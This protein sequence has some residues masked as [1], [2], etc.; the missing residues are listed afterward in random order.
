MKPRNVAK[1]LYMH[2]LGY[3][4]QFGALEVIAL[5]AAPQFTAKRI[6]YLGLML[7]LDEE[8]ELLMMVTNSLRQDLTHLNQFVVGLALSA[9][10]N[11]GSA[12]MGRDLAPDIEALL[13]SPNAYIRKK[14]ALCA[15]R[16]VRK[17]PEMAERYSSKVKALLSDKNHG[18]VLT[19]L[20]L[21]IELCKCDPQYVAL[22]RPAVPSL[23][24]LLKSLVISGNSP[25][26]EVGGICDPFLQVK[27]L[28]AL[29]TLGTRDAKASDAMNDILAQVTTNTES[30]RNVGNAILYEAV[31]TILTIEASE[32]LRNLAI[33][34]LGRFLANRDNN[35][36]YVAL[37]SLSKVVNTN[38]SAVQ[39]HRAT[40][41]ENLKVRLH[42]LGVTDTSHSFS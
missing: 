7:L 18:V 28:Q 21:L 26:Y 33:N 29:R 30:L 40:I 31:H 11:V 25:E 24:Q 8:T 41:I 15:V 32:N 4:T 1:L 5:C 35:I 37:N 19:G 27:L 13:A 23:V 20:Q 16:V 17:V 38:F 42:G 36:R 6:G 10:G 2:M 14:A 39:R 34:I 3:S 12:Q 22:F 9:L